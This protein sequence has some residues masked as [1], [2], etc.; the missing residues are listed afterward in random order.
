VANKVERILQKRAIV[1][2]GVKRFYGPIK[3]EAA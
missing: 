3:N 2:N 1:K